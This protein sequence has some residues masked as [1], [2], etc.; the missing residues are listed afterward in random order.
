MDVVIPG[1]EPWEAVVRNPYIWHFAFHAVPN[2]PEVLVQGHQ[3][4][5]F[6][7]FY[8]A[9]SQDPTKI[10]PA[11]RDAYA[12]AYSAS[13]SLTAGFNWYRAF[14]ADAE[15]NQKTVSNAKVAT[16]LLYVRGERETGAIDAYV[17]GL[18]GAGMINVEHKLIPSAGHF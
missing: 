7:F 5:Y 8:D 16:P 1:V 10:A 2:L 9:L 13:N 3:R 12:S 6:D 14:P 18:R 17:Q 15:E 4:T 11:L